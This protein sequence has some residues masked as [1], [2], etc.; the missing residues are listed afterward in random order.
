MIRR[1]PRSTRTDTLFPDTT[2]LR[3]RADRPHRVARHLHGL[4]PS[5]I[6]RRDR[7]AWRAA[8][9]GHWRRSPDAGYIRPCRQMRVAYGAGH[10]TTRLLARGHTPCA[11]QR[12]L[13]EVQNGNTWCRDREVEEWWRW[14]C[15]IT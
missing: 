11:P 15:A 14:G 10:G 5:G 13:C 2:L 7:L 6:G 9:Q 1:P 12:R 8:C 3:S 4:L